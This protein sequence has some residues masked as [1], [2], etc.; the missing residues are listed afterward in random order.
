MNLALQIFS[1]GDLI[2]LGIIAGAII[3]AGVAMPSFGSLLNFTALA[4]VLFVGGTYA[5]ALAL[6]GALPGDLAR[7]D[8][9]KFLSMDGR[10]LLTYAVSFAILV[11]VVRIL[12]GLVVRD[13][14][15]SSRSRSTGP[16]MMSMNSAPS[17]A[18]GHGFAGNA[19][20]DSHG[21]D[22]HGHGSDAHG[23]DDHGHDDHGH[24]S[25]AHAH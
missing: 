4:L 1:T 2:R 6:N 20:S 17:T 9:H 12:R 19:V 14:G 11:A 15:R 25:K 23:H 18:M 3:I 21:H 16:A 5:R 10:H 22:D 13:G 7:E 24:A 8:W